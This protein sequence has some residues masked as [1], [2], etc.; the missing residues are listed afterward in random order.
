MLQ[1][2][3]TFGGRQNQN[4]EDFISTIESN[5]KLVP[6]GLDPMDAMSILLKDNAQV[7]YRGIERYIH[8][9]E[10]LKAALRDQYCDPDYQIALREEITSRVQGRD[11]RVGNYISCM[12]GLYS[13]C[14][15][16]WEMREQVRYAYRG[17]KSH[18]KIAIQCTEKLTLKELE[19]R[20]R[21]HEHMLLT[22][23]NRPV[24]KAANNS[25]CPTF[26]YRPT[27]E[28]RGFKQS[29]KFDN[30]YRPRTSTYTQLNSLS[31]EIE[32]GDSSDGDEQEKMEMLAIFGQI[33][34]LSDEVKSKLPYHI[35][36]QAARTN[37]KNYAKPWNKTNKKFPPRKTTKP[38]EC[39]D[40]GMKGHWAKKCS[41][42]QNNRHQDQN[43]G[44]NERNQNGNIV[45]RQQS[46]T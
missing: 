35:Q 20:A 6:N 26:A 9:W 44:E 41:H 21:K 1:I 33:D 45:S 18:L 7:W 19:D 42:P 30:Q 38:T 8:N 3:A 36:E 23:A 43:D 11:V 34:G 32:E 12:R 15:P 22:D 13:R 10:E 29:Q 37:E 39:F 4:V 24:P 46:S 28:N 40:C 5:W 17:L 25:L 31:E 16:Q 14:L 27:L 2:N